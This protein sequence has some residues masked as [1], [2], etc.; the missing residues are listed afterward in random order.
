M[1]KLQIKVLQIFLK[2]LFES[3][4][5][6]FANKAKFLNNQYMTCHLESAWGVGRNV[7]YL[8]SRTK[9][10]EPGEWDVM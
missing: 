4:Y 1:R 6:N 9:C 7:K 5:Y 8:G 10:K 3:S 2:E